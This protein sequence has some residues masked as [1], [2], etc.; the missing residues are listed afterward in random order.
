MKQQ[1]KRDALYSIII[2]LLGAGVGFALAIYREGWPDWV[3]FVGS[4]LFLGGALGLI[5]T[6]IYHFVYRPWRDHLEK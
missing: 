5:V 6:P 4:L 3:Q 1:Y 2:S